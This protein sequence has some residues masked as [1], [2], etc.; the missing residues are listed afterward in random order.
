[1][2]AWEGP[3]YCCVDVEAFGSRAWRDIIDVDDIDLCYGFTEALS[4]QNVV[5]VVTILALVFRPLVIEDVDVG[6]WR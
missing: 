1:M 3:F 4:T 6:T 5:N 2:Y